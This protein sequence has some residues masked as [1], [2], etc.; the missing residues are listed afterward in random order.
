MERVFIAM[1]SGAVL[2]VLLAI[3]A[4]NP[5][6]AIDCGKNRSHNVFMGTRA[7]GDTL[8]FM[9][10]PKQDGKFLRRISADVNSGNLGKI[11]SY[12]EVIDG[13]TNGK[14]GCA[15]LTTGGVGNLNAGF[16]LKSQ[17]GQ[18]LDFTVRIFGH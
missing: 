2:A 12:I 5:A 11:I 6:V 15:Y 8:L 1:T 17:T 14:G 13:Y 4:P 10:H 18:G 3:L 9:D 16:H 7:Y